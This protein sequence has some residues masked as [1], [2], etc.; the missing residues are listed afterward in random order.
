MSVLLRMD[1]VTCR[2]AHDVVLSSVDLTI[3]SGGFFG[4]VGPSGSGKSTLLKAI[5]GTMRPVAG[6]VYR[7]PGLELAYVDVL[8]DDDLPG[9]PGEDEHS[10]LG[11]MRF[12]YM[13]MVEALGGDPSALGEFEVSNVAPDRAE[14]PQ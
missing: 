14:Y 12:D 1:G 5:M 13:T 6:D 4:V 7:A 11:L 9:E 2:Y 8:R 3:P 10:W